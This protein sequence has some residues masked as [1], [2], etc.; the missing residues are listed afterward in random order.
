MA[1]SLQAYKKLFF[2]YAD[3]LKNFIYFRVGDIAVAEDLVQ[4]TF[5]ILWSK[6]NEI[7][8]TTVKS[9]L[10][11]IA[12]NLSKNYLKHKTVVLSFA[13]KQHSPPSTESPQQILEHKEFTEKLARAITDL[14]EAQR[15]TFLMNRIEQLTYFEIAERL[16]ISVKTVE[17]RMSLA[18]KQLYKNLGYKL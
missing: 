7:K 6:R 9:L 14:S 13:N 5:I 3:T 8:E 4:E 18:L 10:Y 1:I 15:T 17:K 12:S 16:S 2:T 11:T